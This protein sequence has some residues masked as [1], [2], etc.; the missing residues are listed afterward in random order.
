MAT[1]NVNSAVSSDTLNPFCNDNPTETIALG[2][3]GEI[4]YGLSTGNKDLGKLAGALYGLIDGLGTQTTRRGY[5][6]LLGSISLT[7][8]WT[9]STSNN[10][11]NGI[12]GNLLTGNELNANEIVLINGKASKVASVITDNQ[13]TL[14]NNSY[15]NLAGVT[16]DRVKTTAELLATGFNK[17]ITS[18]TTI[19]VDYT[20]GSDIN[21]SLTSSFATLQGAINYL[22][23]YSISRDVLVTINVNNNCGVRASTPIYFSHPQGENVKI[24]ALN[25]GANIVVSSMS[26]ATPT[27]TVNTSTA[28]GLVANDYVTITGVTPAN[29]NLFG[30]V[31]STPSSTQFTIT[32]GAGLTIP[33]YT[34]GGIVVKQNNV[35]TFN[36]T[37]GFIVDGKIGELNIAC[38]QTGTLSGEFK[39][40]VLI[41]GLKEVVGGVNYYNGN[42]GVNKGKIYSRNFTFGLNLQNSYLGNC[43]LINN[44]NFLANLYSVNSN[45]QLSNITSNY[46]NPNDGINSINSNITLSNLTACNCRI[47]LSL[48]NRSFIQNNIIIKI[49][50]NSLLDISLGQSSW[51]FGNGITV[52]YNMNI[53]FDTFQTSGDTF[54]CMVRS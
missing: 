22:S 43:N 11:V 23:K 30:I 18:N 39:S 10:I 14:V 9:T 5:S 3:D 2:N 35:F 27:I 32:W 44:E 33:A 49:G 24:T 6:K 20:T 40:G 41:G 15:E 8:T 29:Y 7:G 45:I 16:I 51:T 47:A 28:H 54:G 42:A 1:F 25:E 4:F 36:N 48:G 52:A 38:S 12:G 13:F 21:G 17:P 46:S 26:Y 50:N 19:T 53:P 37:N 34:S 31:A